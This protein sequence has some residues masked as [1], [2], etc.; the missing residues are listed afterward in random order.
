MEIFAEN[1][2]KRIN[3]LGLTQAEAPR[4]CDLE[5]RRF[6]HYVVGDRQPDLATLVKIA[7]VL[8]TTPDALLSAKPA[9]TAASDETSRLRAKLIA[10][11]GM[12]D[13]SGLQLLSLFADGVVAFLRDGGASSPPRSRARRRPKKRQR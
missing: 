6:H 5:N 13:P 4:R 7:T 12:M 9:T 3:D 2:R 10:T 8:G 1:L 11:A